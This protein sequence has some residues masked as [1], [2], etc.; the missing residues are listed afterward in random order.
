[1][2]LIIYLFLLIFGI[3]GI[4]D[5]NTLTTIT[6]STAL[7]IGAIVYKIKANKKLREAY[8]LDL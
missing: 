7:I 5:A 8:N 2:E 4:L 3:N 1:M 6:L